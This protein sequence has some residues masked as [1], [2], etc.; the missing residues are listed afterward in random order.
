MTYKML[1]E[2]L[3]TLEASGEIN[4]DTLVCGYA[5][6]FSHLY[7]IE[8]NAPITIMPE[9]LVAEQEDLINY[10]KNPDRVEPSERNNL[11]I[12]KYELEVNR[13]KGLGKYVICIGG[14]PGC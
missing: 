5:D 13:L 4:D 2:K 3:Q 11:R 9:I 14:V 7:E 6:E 10:L 12:A 8:D 1:K